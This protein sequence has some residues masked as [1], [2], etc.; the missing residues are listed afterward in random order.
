MDRR[1][2]RPFWRCHRQ[3]HLYRRQRIWHRLLCIRLQRAFQPVSLLATE[4]VT[5]PICECNITTPQPH[6]IFQITISHT[7][8]LQVS[9]QQKYVL[10]WPVRLSHRLKTLLIVVVVSRCCFA[11]GHTRP[12]TDCLTFLKYPIL[13]R[14]ASLSRVEITWKT[15]QSAWI[16]SFQP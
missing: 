12:Q 2:L 6:S 5:A 7:A 15:V 13:M 1:C 14:F 4:A 8:H 11:S 3:Q 16:G 9:A 10:L